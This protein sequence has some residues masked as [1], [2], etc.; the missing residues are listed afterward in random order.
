MA[1]DEPTAASV[2]YEVYT[3][4]IVPCTLVSAI[5][6]EEL[7]G[8]VSDSVQSFYITTGKEVNNK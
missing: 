5:G 1:L 3:D 2:G 7:F 4:P 6:P 8:A